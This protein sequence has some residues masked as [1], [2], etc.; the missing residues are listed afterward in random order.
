MTQKS[1]EEL[2]G[3]ANAQSTYIDYAQFEDSAVRRRAAKKDF[4][5]GTVY[6]PQY[7]YPKLDYHYDVDDKGGSVSDKKRAI[8]EAIF[9][10][11][12]HRGA[13][14][15]SDSEIDLNA[16]FHES[17]LKKILLVESARRLHHAG[18]SN[19]YLLAREEFMDLNKE[20]YGEM[21]RAS[22]DSMMH[23]EAGRVDA[24]VPANEKAAHIKQYLDNYFSRHDF[25][26]ASPE[27]PLIH[28]ELMEKLQEVIQ[29]RYADILEVVPETGDDVYYDAEQCRDIMQRALEVNGLA[30]KGWVIEINESKSNPATNADLK[31]VF[32]PT[33][34]S[35]NA[36]QLRRLIVHEI[37]VHARRAQNG[38][39]TGVTALGKGTADYADVEE[40]LGVLLECVIAGDLDN[41][42]FNRAR[43]RYITA[44]LALGV[45]GVP[46]DGPQTFELLWRLL[47][48]KNSENGEI[49]EK[50]ERAAMD[51]AMVHI[52]NA[53]RGT[54]FAMTGIIYTKLKVYFEGFSKNAK[55][56]AEAKDLNAALD[57][58]MIGKYNH[59]DPKETEVVASI[60]ASKTA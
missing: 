49:D 60:V 35:R 15:I 47:A 28:D 57:T 6:A 32:L 20:L 26:R 19:A 45:D 30:A 13:G 59:V 48:V 3:Y 43:D 1:V 14:L 11:E 33:N 16:S 54:N 25:E 39:E 53:F 18:S 24:F 40:G 12:A 5:D 44:G 29:E 36:Q 2:Q 56:F 52:E 58:A 51:Q 10:L 17:V 50:A 41:Q 7:E 9:E 8:L 4:L 55:F 42:S 23:T 38:E 27:A 37:E 46:K 22:F 21:D 31:K 34:T